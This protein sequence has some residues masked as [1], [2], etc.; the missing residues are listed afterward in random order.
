MAGIKGFTTIEVARLCRVSDATV[1]RW[2]ETGALKSERTSGGH[3]RFRAEEVARFQR[4]KGLGLKQRHGD[5]S[6]K[7]TT[8]RVRDGRVKSDSTFLQSLIAGGEEA[9]TNFLLT[10]HL[11][12]MLLTEI[13]D[14]H[15]CP[16]MREIGELW[17][18]G[19]ISVT[20]EHLATRTAVTAIYKLRNALPVP[21]MSDKLAVCCSMEGDLHDLPTLLAQIAVENEGVEVIN[22][23]AATPLYCMADEVVRHSP[24]FICISATVINDLER[25]TRE[26]KEFREKISTLKIP[27]LLGG[28][29]FEDDSLRRRFEC[30]FYA[31]SFTEA[32][33]FARKL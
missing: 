17:H 10:P 22:F 28:R 6:V 3:R 15:I 32:A 29:V 2:E 24:D 19:E 5:E 30:E 13:I 8:N 18:R 23:G 12:G 16:A 31:R 27:I 1:K 9:A 14:R 26:Y 7:K 21:T 20:Q 25:L 33:E 11:E 4:E